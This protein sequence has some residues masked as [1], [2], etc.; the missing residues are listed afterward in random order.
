MEEETVRLAHYEIIVF[1]Y[2]SK[3]RYIVLK[4]G[5]LV[6]A[7]DVPL[8]TELEKKLK[9]VVDRIVKEVED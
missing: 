3:I 4:F 8:F 7:N 6:E 5:K 2:G 1:R 9:E